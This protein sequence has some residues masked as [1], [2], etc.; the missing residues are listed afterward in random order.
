[1]ERDSRVASEVPTGPRRHV[2]PGFS[3]GTSRGRGRSLRYG[4]IDPG[5]YPRQGFRPLGRGSGYR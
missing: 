4:R 3:M 5:S 2:G 1:V